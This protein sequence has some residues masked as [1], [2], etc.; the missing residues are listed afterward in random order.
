MT[1]GKLRQAWCFRGMHLMHDQIDAGDAGVI[2]LLIQCHWIVKGGIW[3]FLVVLDKVSFDKVCLWPMML[4]VLFHSESSAA[5]PPH[6]KPQRSILLP[7]ESIEE[8]GPSLV[9]ESCA[10]I[11]LNVMSFYFPHNVCF[12]RNLFRAEQRDL[13]CFWWGRQAICRY[14]SVW[15]WDLPIFSRAGLTSIQSSTSLCR[16]SLSADSKR[17]VTSHCRLKT[18]FS[19]NK[20]LNILP[21]RP[22]GDCGVSALVMK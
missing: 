8:L 22:W 12:H 18:S 7:S 5:I 20:L 13:F 14:S 11:K 19:L 21:T 4:S 17:L 6:E 15:T 10:F 3:Y 16:V 9:K 1:P 2:T